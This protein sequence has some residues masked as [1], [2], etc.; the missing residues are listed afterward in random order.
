MT[1]TPLPMHMQDLKTQQRAPVGG[2]TFADVLTQAKIHFSVNDTCVLLCSRH[3]EAGDKEVPQHPSLREH[4]CGRN[5]DL[6]Q[7]LN[8]WRKS[9]PSNSEANSKPYLLNSLR[10]N[11]TLRASLCHVSVFNASVSRPEFSLLYF[12]FLFC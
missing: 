8:L 1:Q 5:R 7:S 4:I 10:F 2:A 12:F 9:Q 3:R 11:C 6:R